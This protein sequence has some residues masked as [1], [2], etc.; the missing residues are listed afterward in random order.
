MALRGLVVAGAISAGAA[1][2]SPQGAKAFD[3]TGAWATAANKC[4]KVFVRK[5][6]DDKVIFTSFSGVYGGGFMVEADRLRGK[7]ESCKIKSRKEGDRTF[8]LVAAC[9]SGV[10]LSNVQ[11]VLKVIDDNTIAREFPGIDDMAV[12]YYR[13]RI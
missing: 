9:A 1:V 8:N 3:L 6:R 10:M 11:F 7:F 13:C 5:G 2:L 12:K 4:T